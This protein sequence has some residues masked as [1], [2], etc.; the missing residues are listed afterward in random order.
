MVERQI[1]R[2]GVRDERVLDAVAAV[3]RHLFV[4]PDAAALAYEDHPLA[5]G[6]GQ[7]ISQPYIVAFMT[8]CLQVTP[9]LRVLE[10]GTGSGYQ[11]AVLA[12]LGCTVV[13]VER[14]PELAA[15]A[16]RNLERAGYGPAVD[17][18]DGDGSVGLPDEGPFARIIV[19]AAGPTVPPSLVAQLADDG[20][21][22][23]P[24]G[25]RWSQD[26]VR[27]RRTAAGST[28]ETVLGCVFVPLIGV[29]GWKES[30]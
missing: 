23:L 21:L 18:R 11:A 1:R 9:G 22:L 13:T 16:R 3:P 14:L 17:V 29:E 4:P 6:S 10:I 20:I 24:V 19:T 26:L 15:T 25:G 5:I 12:A 2:R 30:P 28:R 7:T 27:I 8:E